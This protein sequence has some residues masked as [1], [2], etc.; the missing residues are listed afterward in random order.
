MGIN[1]G[2]KSGITFGCALAIAISYVHNHSI[3]WAIIH[4]LLSWIY[5]IYAA[6]KY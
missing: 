4:G 5:V 2:A 3:L 6:L 1:E